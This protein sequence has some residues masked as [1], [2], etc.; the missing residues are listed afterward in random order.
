MQNPYSYYQSLRFVYSLLKYNE[1]I[2]SSLI[3]KTHEYDGLQGENTPV[4]IIIPKKSEKKVVILYPGASPTAEDHPKM[5]MLGRLWAQVG[6]TVYIPRIP[7]LKNLD[8]SEINVQWFAHFY[9]WILEIEKVNPH[10]IIMVGISYGG[11]IMLK[12]LLNI[13]DRA[14]LPKTL[15]TYGTYSDAESTL[16][17][18]LTGEISIKE[19]TYQIT[20]HEWGLTVLFHNYLKNLETEWDT[21]GFQ[22]AIQL[23]IQD[24][25]EECDKLVNTLP[26]FQ[27]N[28]Y[29]SIIT[30]N[31]TPEV[32]ELA[33]AII[34]N[35]QETLK[36]LSPKYWANNFQKKVFILHG[37]NDSMVP[38]TESIQLAEDLPNSELF[39]SY[40]YEHSEFSTNRGLFFTSM[41][42]I[43]FI[44]YYSKLFYH[45]EN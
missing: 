7:P 24:K 30:G 42:I 45:H 44:Q 4:K 22:R 2:S 10:Q 18:L 32:K 13:K 12:T 33:Q 25:R 17:F 26:K 34:K 27:K 1:D 31:P 21:S 38:F 20:P 6:F 29:F 28:I 11:G 37:S 16:K 3:I 41:E 19:T 36:R 8:I 14:L 9:Q 15:L 5:V 43:K 40:L 35:E 23:H 39:I